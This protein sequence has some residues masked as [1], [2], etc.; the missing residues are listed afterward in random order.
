MPT[1]PVYPLDDILL[2]RVLPMDARG[3][4]CTLTYEQACKVFDT[5]NQL[6]E[7]SGNF[8]YSS[9][10]YYCAQ[11]VPVRLSPEDWDD[12]QQNTMLKLCQRLRQPGFRAERLVGLLK[13]IVHD[14]MVN[15]QRC[16]ER[17]P[18]TW[19]NEAV[20]AFHAGAE[21]ARLSSFVQKRLGLDEAGWQHFQRDLDEEVV[22]L[23]A[24]Q[25]EVALLYIAH[26][27][28]LSDRHKYSE[29]AQLMTRSTGKVVS[30]ATIKSNLRAATRTLKRRLEERGYHLGD[31]WFF[32]TYPARA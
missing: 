19:D 15:I 29:L 9:I 28:V 23:P 21:A 2:N 17:L 14:E 32:Y 18:P 26:Y 6:T 10:S 16:R 30:A 4:T 5:P 7:Y 22:T 27:E 11:D 24:C 13:K 20:E 25:R 1:A 12:V 8:L 31:N 3:F